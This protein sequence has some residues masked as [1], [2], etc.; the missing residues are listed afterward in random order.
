SLTFRLRRLP[1]A[2][3]APVMVARRELPA[4]ADLAGSHLLAVDLDGDGSDEIVAAG[5][6]GEVWAFGS[7][8]S[9]HV[10]RDG[11]PATIEPLAV[12]RDGA[13]RPVVWNL[14]G[15]AGDLDGDGALEIVLTGPDGLYGFDAT[16]DEIADGDLDPA[17]FGRLVALEDCRIP[18]VLMPRLL[19]ADPG[20]P[21]AAVVVESRAGASVLRFL[22]AAG[23]E[24]PDV[25]LGAVAVAAPP[26]YLDHGNT[27]RV[28]VVVTDTTAGETALVVVEP[29]ARG[30]P[31]IGAV[32]LP[33][34]PAPLPP[35]AVAVEPAAPHRVLQ[36]LA[37]GRV[38]VVDLAPG[39]EPAGAGVALWSERLTARGPVAP[40]GALAADGLFGVALGGGVWDDGWPARPDPPVAPRLTAASPLPLAARDERGGVRQVFTARD[41]RLYLYDSAGAL[42][43]GWPLAGPGAAAGTPLLDDLDGDGTVELVAAGAFQR[44]TGLV[45]TGEALQTEARSELAVWQLEGLQPG[46]VR[47]WGG[48]PWRAGAWSTEPAD[49]AEG[50]SGLL[51]DASVVCY[52][53]PLTVPTLRVR[54]TVG[55]ACRVRAVIYNLEGEQVAAAEPRQVPAGTFELEVDLARAVTG[56]YLCRLEAIQDGRR[57]DSV[58]TVAVVR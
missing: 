45:G 36:V 12:G 23:E 56:L 35:V 54:G 44:I 19:G 53:S 24:W 16:G 6:A 42:Q 32:P 49:G 50:L 17:S 48:S 4:G 25:N 46:P 5:Q 13:G 10:D 58:R 28:A 3:A 2:A 11:D 57:S 33:G 39:D 43:E 26:A 51:D 9:E 40:T 31:V 20:A 15:A 7:D 1:A 52:P 8:L 21:A 37:D 27:G 14:P 30:N 55:A 22:T 41:G 18:A 34:P 29:S 47:Q 38:A